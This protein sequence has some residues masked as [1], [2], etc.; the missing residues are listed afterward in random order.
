MAYRL[1]EAVE[2]EWAESLSRVMLCHEFRGHY[3]WP[4]DGKPPMH[5]GNDIRSSPHHALPE[6]LSHH[7]EIVVVSIQYSKV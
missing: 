7:E 1:A 2:Y 5:Q 3:K 4:R 6:D